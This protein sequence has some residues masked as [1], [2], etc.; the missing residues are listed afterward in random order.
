MLS[1]K[2]QGGD[3]PEGARF[4]AYRDHSP[5]TEV[6]TTRFVNERTLAATERFAVVAADCGM[7]LA[8]FAVAWTLTREFVGSTLIGATSAT[9]STTRSP[10]RT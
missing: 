8:T 4:S 1:G 9:S 2:Y 5:R 3:W 10:R 7:E 6:M